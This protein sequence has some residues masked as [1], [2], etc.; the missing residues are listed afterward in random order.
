MQGIAE[1]W[2][3]FAEDSKKNAKNVNS[4][5]KTEIWAEAMSVDHKPA[6]ESEKKR[7][8]A[9][10]HVV[11]TNTWQKRGE[12]SK[13]PLDIYRVDGLLSTSRAIGDWGFKDKANFPPQDQAVTCVPEIVSIILPS[14]YFHPNKSPDPDPLPE[15]NNNNSSSNSHRSPLK[16]TNFFY[17]FLILASD[18]MWDV[19]S[20][21]EAVQFVSSRLDELISAEHT[22][23][24]KLNINNA[25]TNELAEIVCTDLVNLALTKLSTDNVSAVLIVFQ[26]D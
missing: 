6:F 17:R 9:A 18:G 19:I 13:N 10:G 8:I 15:S 20:N 3:E 21:D 23:N 4:F 26:Q 11:E 16:S 12:E 25:V 22:K 24:G 2:Q 5:C 7:I 14:P 1:P